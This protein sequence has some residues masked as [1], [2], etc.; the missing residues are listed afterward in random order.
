MR[1]FYLCCLC[2]AL[3]FSVVFGM[4][5]KLERIK[6]CHQKC[7]EKFSVCFNDPCYAGTMC[8]CSIASNLLSMVGSAIALSFKS[9]TVITILFSSSYILTVLC[10]T[11]GGCWYLML[12]SEYNDSGDFLMACKKSFIEKICQLFRVAGP[13]DQFAKESLV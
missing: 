13:D 4:E 6:N 5:R 3:Q 11:C 12:T 9:P 10:L 8:T 2:L 1:L 7:H